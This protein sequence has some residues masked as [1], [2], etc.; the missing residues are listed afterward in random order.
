[1]HGSTCAMG[2]G[3]S[4]LLA[5]LIPPRMGREGGER[6]MNLTEIVIF[7]ITMIVLVIVAR[8]SRPDK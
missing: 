4:R 8:N 3:W 5:C 7:M 6:Y 2:A 1:M